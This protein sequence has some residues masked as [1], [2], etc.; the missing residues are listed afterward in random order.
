MFW[1]CIVALFKIKGR[2]VLGSKP[3]GSEI[4]RICPHRPWGPHNLLYN[5][6]RVFSGGKER[7]WRDSD[8][9]PPS[10]AVV[11]KEYSYNSTP[12]KGRTAFAEPQCLY[13]RTIPLL[14]PWT[15]RSLQSLR[16]CTVQLHL[17]SP[18]GT[19]GLYRASVPVQYSYTSTPL[20]AILPVQSLGGSTVQLYL[21]SPYGPYCL[22]RASVLV[23]YIYTS[24]PPMDRTACTEP[25]CLY[26]TA[27]PLLPL[28]AARP[29]R[30][31][32]VCTRSHFTF[33]FWIGIHSSISTCENWF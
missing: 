8:P 32:S 10:S 17:Y 2:G 29:L 28:W 27:I 11:K 25:Q 20:Q 15:A 5:R 22:Y 26:S 3:A 31:L 6:Y 23:Q 4:F 33:Y 24:T 16:A 14:P 13:S 9:S 1:Y 19:Y 18:Y 21:Y 7:P 30:S 12:P